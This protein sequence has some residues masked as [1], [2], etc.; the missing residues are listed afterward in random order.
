[1]WRQVFMSEPFPEDA[2]SGLATRQAQFSGLRNQTL[3]TLGLLLI[4]LCLGQTVDLLREPQDP[5]GQDSKAKIG[6]LRRTPIQEQ[7]RGGSHYAPA[8]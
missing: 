8:Q 2:A 7:L 3:F 5:P 4:E 6:L 1:M